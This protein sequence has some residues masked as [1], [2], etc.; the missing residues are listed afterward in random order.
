[1]QLVSIGLVPSV[2][3]VGRQVVGGVNSVPLGTPCSGGVILC[4][5]HSPPAVA[6]VAEIYPGEC[7]F[8]TEIRNREIKAPGPCEDPDLNSITKITID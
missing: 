3:D 1:M 8:D 5:L 6:M 2:P 4:I 7:I